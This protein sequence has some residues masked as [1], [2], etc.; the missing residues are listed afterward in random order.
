MGLF[1]STSL[2]LPLSSLI[3]DREEGERARREEEGGSGGAEASIGDDD[4]N[5]SAV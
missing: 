1:S 5:A 4:A 3:T 2:A